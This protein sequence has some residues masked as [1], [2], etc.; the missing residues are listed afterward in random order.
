MGRITALTGGGEW[1]D[2]KH[3]APPH[4]FR[5]CWGLGPSEHRSGNLTRRGAIP[6]TSHLPARKAL[7]SVS[8]KYAAPPQR[9]AVASAGRVGPRGR[10]IVE[11]PGPVVQEIPP[12]PSDSPAPDS[13]GGA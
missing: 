13:R 7:V 6:Q 5:A 9:A 3:L 4:P 2:V 10:P 8:W 11:G 1:G 12:T